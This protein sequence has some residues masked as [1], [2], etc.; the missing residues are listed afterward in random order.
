MDEREFKIFSMYRDEIERE[1]AQESDDHRLKSLLDKVSEMLAEFSN[2]RYEAVD[3][4]KKQAG[5]ALPLVY[6]QSERFQEWLPG[7]KRYEA[8]WDNLLSSMG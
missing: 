4:A 6:R 7:G 3:H 2:D 1:S 8:A 5:Q